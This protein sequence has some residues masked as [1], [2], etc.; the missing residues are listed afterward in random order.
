MHD[1]IA[2]IITTHERPRVAQRLIDSIRK[3]YGDAPNIYICDD[4]RQPHHYRGAYNIPPNAYDIGLSAKRNILVRRTEEP[5]VFLWDDDYICTEDTHIEKFYQ[6]LTNQEDIGIVGGNWMIGERRTNWF[7]GEVDYI[8]PLRTHRPPPKT[9]ISASNGLGVGPWVRVMFTPNWF[10]AARE[11]LERLPWDESLPLQEHI[12][13]FCRLAA[14]RAPLNPH[15]PYNG[16]DWKWR[17]R[18]IRRATGCDEPVIDSEGRMN[19]FITTTLMNKKHLGGTAQRNTW[20]KVPKEYGEHLVDNGY[21]K[22]TVQ[23]EE[24]RPFYLPEVD[25][26][27]PLGVALLLDTTCLHDRHSSNSDKYVKQRRDRDWHHIKNQK[28]GTSEV[29]YKQWQVPPLQEHYTY[30]KDHLQLPDIEQ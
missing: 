10:L 20:H 9:L 22:T 8:G 5:Y 12:E 28:M 11:T 4:S 26:D 16:L 17:K 6:L 3:N 7:T 25:K 19:V 14:I 29:D 13:W 24:A 21:A 2:H 23:M 30:T 27:V 1:E 18:Y 15:W